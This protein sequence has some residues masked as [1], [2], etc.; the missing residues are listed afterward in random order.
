MVCMLHYLIFACKLRADLPN[1]SHAANGQPQDSRK[2][3]PLANDAGYIRGRIL[4]SFPSSRILLPS[5]STLLRQLFPEMKFF[6][7][8]VVPVLASAVASVLGQTI[9]LG[10]PTD[11]TILYPGQNFTA[12]IILPVSIRYPNYH[13]LVH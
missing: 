3:R 12:Q 7:F 11:G 6:K 13:A 8:A 4:A 5:P 1:M 2:W 9:E 10:T